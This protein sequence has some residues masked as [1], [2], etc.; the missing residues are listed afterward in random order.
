MTTAYQLARLPIEAAQGTAGLLLWPLRIGKTVATN[1]VDMAFKLI[2]A[3][4]ED[5]VLSIVNG[6]EKK[7]N[8]IHEMAVSNLDIA[9][10]IYYYTELR[11][12]TKK[13]LRAF[14]IENGMEIKSVD[15]DDPCDL[16]I[17]YNALN[18][19][20]KTEAGLRSPEPT[21]A[22]T[23][24]LEEYRSS[25]A[26]L[27]DLKTR[28]GLDKGDIDVFQTY[29]EILSQP[30]TLTGIKSDL[31]RYDNLIDAQFRLAFGGSEFNRT[32]IDRIIASSTSKGGSSESIRVHHIDDDFAST[33][34]NISG[35]VKG[36]AS[37]VVWAILVDDNKKTITVVFRGSVSGADWLTNFQSNMVDFELPGFTSEET[38]ETQNFGMVHEG[39]YDY[40][41]GETN[42]GYNGSTKS[43][44]EEIMGKLKADF[45]DKPEY[46]NYSLV[47]TGHSLGASLSTMF[48]VRAAALNDFP[49][50]T[51]VTNISFASPFVGDEAFRKSFMDLEKSRKIRHLRISNDE[52][53]VPL[54]P[55]TTWPLPN[56]LKGYKHVG[57]NIRL[58]K[59]GS[60]LAPAYRR[61]YPKE[62]SI[63][64]GLRNTA[65]NELLSL[66]LAVLALLDNHLFSEHQTR[67][68]H[69]ETE[70]ELIK[71]TLD[72]LY[73]NRSV[74]GWDYD[75]K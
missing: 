19:V 16:L 32:I 44:G 52:D 38:K 12:A 5:D 15:N 29:F 23:K 7:D 41:F 22:G 57:M 60:L 49:E 25:L 14:A 67:L 68:E 73:D 2:G 35:F 1:T 21:D 62:E 13:K 40:M 45:F 3:N 53:I 17:L 33:S 28:F 74:T 31:I 36:F 34:L 39:F 56:G 75:Q 61:F 26:Q 11:S 69:E 70:K 59:P 47:V 24:A 8:S 65:H 55:N 71:F 9:A 4:T 63:V 66:S 43:K 27:E 20:S 42:A 72:D 46:A 51:M 50:G 10:M 54:I 58:Y 37:E 30:K 18:L 48:A 64:D 6:D